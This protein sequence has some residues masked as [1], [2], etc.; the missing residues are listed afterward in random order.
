[1]RYNGILEIKSDGSI[2]FCGIK[3]KF[4]EALIENKS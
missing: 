4:D 1:M 3:A 2:Y